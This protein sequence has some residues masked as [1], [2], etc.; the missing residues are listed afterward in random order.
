MYDKGFSQI[1]EK[2]NV[3]KNEHW[4][5]QLLEKNHYENFILYSVY[6]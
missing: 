1:D 6:K 2:K 3:T 4:C 5:N